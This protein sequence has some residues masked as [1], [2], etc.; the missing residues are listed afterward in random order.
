M[1]R[2]F[3]IALFI[4]TLLPGC[5]TQS[6]VSGSSEVEPVVLAIAPFTNVSAQ[7]QYDWIGVGMGE[8]LSTKLGNLPS[9]QLVERIK[10]SDAISEMKLGQSGLVDESTATK[11]GKVVGAEQLLTG[12][13]QVSGNSIRVDVRILEI[14]TGK[15]YKT[16]GANGYLDNLFEL[17]DRIAASLLTALELPLSDEEKDLLASKP[18]VSP[19]AFR[20]YSQAADTYTP[21]GRTLSDEERINYLEQSTRLDPN[22]AMAYL[23]LGDI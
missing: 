23:M 13:F 16:A 19:E 1:H 15:V 3:L 2:A 18:S 11:L 10:L 5:A 14:E 6:R 20:L 4:L 9:F 21:E 8:A 7:K 17:Q 22:F 12:S